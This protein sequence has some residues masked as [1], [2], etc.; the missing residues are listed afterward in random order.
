MLNYSFFSYVEVICHVKL[1]MSL[2]D[3]V[4]CQR[5]N[6]KAV[7]VLEIASYAEAAS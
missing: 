3:L 1:V 4:F 6:I 2:P 7:N 5:G